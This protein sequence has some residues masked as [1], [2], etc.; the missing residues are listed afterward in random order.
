M[1]SMIT[2]GIYLLYTI[3]VLCPWFAAMDEQGD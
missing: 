2:L 1:T 3:M